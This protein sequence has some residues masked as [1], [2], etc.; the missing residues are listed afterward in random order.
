[1]LPHSL[2]GFTRNVLRRVM[3]KQQVET[4]DGLRFRNK[5]PLASEMTGCLVYCDGDMTV[6]RTEIFSRT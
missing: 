5:H 6:S 3:L 1:M 4:A 2:S